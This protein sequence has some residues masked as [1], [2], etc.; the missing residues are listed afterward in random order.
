MACPSCK[1][2]CHTPER[3]VLSRMNLVMESGSTRSVPGC[4]QKPEGSCPRLFLRSCVLMTLGWSPLGQKFKKKWWCYLCSQVCQ[5]SWET[6]P[7]LV[8][9]GYV[10]L[11]HRISSGH[12]QKLEGSCPGLV[13]S[14]CVL[15]FPGGSL[16]AEVVILPVLTGVPV[17][18]ENQPSPSDIWAWSTVAQNHLWVQMETGSLGIFFF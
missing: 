16:G 13:L 8:V 17:L 14:S 18:L 4:R 2:V 6:S 3:P 15:R 5:Q 11:C 9:F 1:L 10:V 12:R 7:L